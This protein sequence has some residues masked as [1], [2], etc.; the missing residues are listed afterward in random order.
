MTGIA[1]H[2]VEL[3]LFEDRN[4]DARSGQFKTAGVGADM[5]TIPAFARRRRR[6]DAAPPFVSPNVIQSQNQGPGPAGGFGLVS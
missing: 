1:G 6:T 5:A 3:I 4:A 2:G